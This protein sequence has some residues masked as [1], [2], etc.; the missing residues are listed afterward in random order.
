LTW[1]NPFNTTAAPANASQ[2]RLALYPGNRAQTLSFAGAVNLSKSTRL[3]VSISPEWMRQ[4]A[5]FLTFTINPAVTNVPQMPGTSL[6]GRKTAIAANVT[7]TSHPLQQ[8]SLTA[9]YGDYD[10][11]NDTPS[12]FFSNYVLNDSALAN[13]ARQS[14]PY[15]F[16]RQSLGLN[17]SWT[18][19]KGET[20]TAGYEFV[21][22]D[23][24][25]RDV[26]KTQ[27]HSGTLTLDVNP[28]RWF[29]LR[30]LYQRSE[31][32]PNDY[33]LNLE[34]YPKG[35]SPPFPTGWE[36]FDEAARTRNKSG[37]VM[38]L[39]ASDRLSFSASFDTTDDN[40]H[41]SL[42]GLL[43]YQSFDSS[44]EVSYAL[45]N[46][47]SLFVGYAFE[48]YKSDQRSRQLSG[49]NNSMN[50]DWESYIA[51]RIQTFSAGISIPR[52]RRNVTLDA[53]YSLAFATGQI[54][55]R[56]LGHPSLPGFLVTTAQ[57]WPQTGT[58]S[59]N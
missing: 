38:E 39:D 56:I 36:M 44:A 59:T 33:T 34:L 22:M 14:L 11:I 18:L 28:K 52:I 51:D 5:P 16:N 12:L 3:M 27:E 8:L 15:S 25:H 21:N 45:R 55:S 13:V 43:G 20:L 6:N 46:D 24:E 29:S 50:N 42:Y 4:N 41:D 1:D 30:T 31:R 2:G 40:F 58:R 35:G 19:H 7:L 53:Y 49:T 17:A 37:A 57:D 48:R 32:N 54:N 47:I 26:A 9:R 23:R 10:Y